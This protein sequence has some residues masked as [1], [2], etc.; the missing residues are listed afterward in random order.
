MSSTLDE[1]WPPFA[2]T[3]TCGDLTLT[4][5]RDADLPELVD[6][7]ASG[8]HHPERMPFPS[9]WSTL[10]MPELGREIASRYWRYRASFTPHKWCLPLVVRW[11]GKVLGVQGAEAAKFPVARTPDTFSWLT[12]SAQRQG[13]GT[14]MRQ[15]IC[16]FLF[17]ELD[18][19]SITSG[20][21]FDNPASLRVSEK[22][23]FRPNGAVQEQRGDGEAVMHQRLILTREHF[24][25]APEPVVVTGAVQFRG[26]A[27]VARRGEE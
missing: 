25:R 10:P 22:V 1:L 13:V 6:A 8:I 11:K 24:V 19:H 26:F 5:V 15:T 4:A 9:A 17:D 18:A 23:G 21:Y 12:E 3:L 2:V 27:G 14:R 7:A 16:A 20:A